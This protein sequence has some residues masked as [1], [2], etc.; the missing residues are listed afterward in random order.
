MHENPVALTYHVQG[1]LAVPSDGVPHQVPVAALAFEA[2]I[3]HAT[4]PKVRPVA[5]LQAGVKNTSDY[6]L[7]AGPIHAFVDNSIVS[8]SAIVGDVAPGDGFR[9]TLGADS[10]T[11]IRYARTSKR[12]DDGDA[13][14]ERSAFS[15]QWATTTCRSCTT[16][17]N[18]HSFVLRGLVLRNGVPVRARVVLR[19]P[20][21]LA[22]LE[23]GEE[24]KVCK[25]EGEKRTVRWSNVVD[26]KG[27]KEGMFE[28]VTEVGAGKRLTI[29]TEWDVK[30]PLSL[31]WVEI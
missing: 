6:G 28:W 29:R 24:L 13:D 21:G 25:V 31:S 5:Y 18:D 20:G 27:G 2:K 10:A 19:R 8:K 16:I 4:V 26:G 14:R 9:C 17:T 15:E 1:E 11:R 3:M 12:A 7:L 23:K 22:V 30:T